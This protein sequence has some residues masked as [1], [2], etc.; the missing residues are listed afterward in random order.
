MISKKNSLVYLLV[1]CLITGLFANILPESVNAQGNGVASICVLEQPGVEYFPEMQVDIRALDANRKVVANM[2][3]SAIKVIEGGV[4]FPINDLKWNPNIAGLD[5]YFVVDL[6]VL[7]DVALMRQI[8]LH[9]ADNFMLDGVDRVSI[10][11]NNPNSKNN[12]LWLAPTTSSSELRDSIEKLPVEAISK[13][14]YMNNAIQAAITASKVDNIGCSRSGAVIVMSGPNFISEFYRS[15]VEEQIIQ[16]GMPLYII[17]NTSASPDSSKSRD[18]VLAQN[19][20]GAYYQVVNDNAADYTKLDASLFGLLSQERGGYSLQYRTKLGDS[21]THNVEILLAGQNTASGQATTSY[22]VDVLP[23]VITIQAPVQDAI[24]ERT[25]RQM[26]GS[27]YIYDKGVQTIEFTIDWPDGYPRKI[28]SLDLL[29]TTASGT[30]TL[31]QITGLDANRYQIGWE[32]AGF[33]QGGDSAVTLEVRLM[34]EFQ[35][36]AS[37]SPRGLVVSNKIDMPLNAK[38]PLWLI[39][40]LSILGLLVLGLLILIFVMRKQ[41]ASVIKGGGGFRGAVA[42]VRKTLAGGAKG[43]KTLAQLVVLEGPAE[44]LKPSTNTLSIKTESIKLGRDPRLADYTFYKDENSSISG[45]HCRIERHMGQ[46]RIVAVS[47][48]RMETFLDEQP[49][50]FDQPINLLSGQTIRLGYPAQQHVTLKFVSLIAD[51][52]PSRVT[53]VN[54]ESQSDVRKTDTDQADNQV[55]M[56]FVNIDNKTNN[57]QSEDLFDEFR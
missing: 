45:L 48:S 57:S 9:Y 32:L 36:E 25:A 31:G 46:W 21:G 55:P 18:I 16:S 35:I 37:S 10:Y 29:V 52:T 34:D 13:F 7:T 3:V 23:A 6:G 41:L 1:A 50:P 38:I 4:E 40:L 51:T 30:E 56:P 54:G 5:L 15:T 49:I 19:T 28:E 33:N 12:M 26:D 11:V 42:E 8:L 47:E 27:S 22:Y 53:D 24:I 39:I 2:P 43:G 17:Q 14:N 20:S 44:L